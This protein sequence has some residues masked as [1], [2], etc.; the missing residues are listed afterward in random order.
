MVP[1][2][3]LIFDEIGFGEGRAIGPGAVGGFYGAMLAKSGVDLNFFSAV[4]TNGLWLIHHAGGARTR[5]FIEAHS[6]IESIGICDWV[7]VATGPTAIPASANRS[8]P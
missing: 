5:G 6:R 4:Q 8:V 3:S 7:I 1:L 2:S